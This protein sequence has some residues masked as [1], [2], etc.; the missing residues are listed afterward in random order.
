MQN[1]IPKIT[2]LGHVHITDLW[3]SI[4]LYPNVNFFSLLDIRNRANK[5]VITIKHKRSIWSTTMIDQIS[6][7]VHSYCNIWVLVWRN[8]ESIT[9]ESSHTR[10]DF[11]KW[12]SCFWVPRLR[13][14]ETMNQFSYLFVLFDCFFIWHIYAQWPQEAKLRLSQWSWISV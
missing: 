6:K 10:Y 14:Y 13:Q 9:V 3:I 4:K 8:W 1:L 12:T 5:H 2:W 7:W 11:L